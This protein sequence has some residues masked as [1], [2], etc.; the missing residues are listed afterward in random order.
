M[1]IAPLLLSLATLG[2]AP[3]DRT[4]YYLSESRVISPDG[5]PLGIIAGIVRREYR[6]G[7]RKIVEMGI[8]LDPAPGS[9]PTVTNIEWTVDGQ[10]ATITERSERI[11]GKGK[12]TGPPWA[13]TDWTSTVTMKDVPGT[14]RNTAKATP[15]GIATRTEQL[16]AS[17]KRLALFDQVDTKI[18]KE[19]YD[20]LRAKLLPQ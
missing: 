20:V 4:E 3:T 18:R 17:G 15:R 13:W 7:E 11:N 12:L 5:K 8:A 9:L 6:P 14:F 19:T 1:P 10:S 16:D 2:Q